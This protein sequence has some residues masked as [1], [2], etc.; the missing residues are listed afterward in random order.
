MSNSNNHFFI[1][2]GDKFPNACLVSF[3]TAIVFFVNGH[4]EADELANN[5]KY[6]RNKLYNL[7][8]STVQ[9]AI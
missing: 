6:A 1:Q 5:H 9:A 8:A 7:G 2:C 4:C 3:L